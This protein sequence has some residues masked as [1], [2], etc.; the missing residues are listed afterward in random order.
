MNKF[1]LVSSYNPAGDQPLAIDALAQGIGCGEKYQTLLGVAGSG[2]TFTLANV[3]A[4]INKPTLVISHKKPSQHSF[5]VNLR[6]S[7]PRTR[8]NILSATMI[9]TSRKPIS[10]QLISI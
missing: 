8:L 7:S 4:K 3:I 6:N 9:I 10:P 2:K 1:K 5:T